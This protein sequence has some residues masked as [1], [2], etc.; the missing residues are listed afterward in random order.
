M[1]GSLLTRLRTTILLAFRSLPLLLMSF[2]GF[3]AIGLG[4]MGL[5]MLFIGQAVIVPLITEAL[6]YYPADSNLINWNDVAQLVPLIPSTGESYSKSVNIFPTYWMAHI[7][8]FFGYLLCNAVQMWQASPDLSA[9][10][11]KNSKDTLTSK[12]NARQEKAMTLM[13]TIFLFFVLT[14]VTRFYATGT[15]LWSGILLAAV[16]LGGAGAAWYLL[17]ELCGATN[18]DIFGIAIQ[19]MTSDSAQDK[20]KVCTYT[21]SASG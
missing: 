6:H 10:K 2:V 15:E 4:N 19:M 21:P 3:L 13:I 12:I 17:A 9:L 5:F 7:S 1:S 16:V 14:C 18:S 20:P 11:N 8:F